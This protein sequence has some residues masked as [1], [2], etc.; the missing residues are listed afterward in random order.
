MLDNGDKV[1]HSLAMTLSTIEPSDSFPGTFNTT[2]FNDDGRGRGRGRGHHEPPV[3]EPA[4]Y[5]IVLVGLCMALLVWRR[6][7][8]RKRSRV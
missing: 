6:L 8:A 7:A 2:Q 4:T 3:P 5:G 1:G